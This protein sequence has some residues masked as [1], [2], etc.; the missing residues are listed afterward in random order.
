LTVKW[1]SKEGR[2]AVPTAAMVTVSHTAPETIGNIIVRRIERMIT[3]Q[4]GGNSS[5]F[6]ILFEN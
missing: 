5:D 6:F 1:T 3:M 4:K 2:T